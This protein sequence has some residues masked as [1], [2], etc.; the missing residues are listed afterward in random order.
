MGLAEF[1]YN[2]A[3]HLT[4]KKP[5]SKVAYEVEPLQ[6]T[7]LVLEGTHSTVEF[8]QDG[9]DLAKKQEQMLEKTK[10][11]L[12]K[13]R[14]RYEKQVKAGRHEMEYKVGQKVLLNVKNFTMLE[15]LTPKFMS[16]FAGLFSIVEWMFNDVY[17]LKLPPEIKVHPRFHVLLL[18]PFKEDNL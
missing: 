5:P 16:K 6:P 4:T 8:N 15:S 10:L 12:E 11:L 14:R 3:T 18:K 1:N 7:N 2:A 9:E 17:K 13:A